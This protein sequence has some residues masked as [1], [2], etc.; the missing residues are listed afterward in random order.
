M[1][2]HPSGGKSL[3][4]Q[5]III[6]GN[7]LKSPV[8]AI[9]LPRGGSRVADRLCPGGRISRELRVVLRGVNAAEELEGARAAAEADRSIREFERASVD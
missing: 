6:D 5:K 7:D 8:S 2:A 1:N 9:A 4:F 3:S